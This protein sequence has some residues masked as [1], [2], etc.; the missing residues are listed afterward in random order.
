M[1]EEGQ[2]AA[3]RAMALASAESVGQSLA[4]LRSMQVQVMRLRLQAT[5]DAV[6]IESAESLNDAIGRMAAALAVNS[7]ETAI[8]GAVALN[9]LCPLAQK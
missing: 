3:I 4:T 6:L 5:G 1:G 8:A 9:E 2:C 7:G